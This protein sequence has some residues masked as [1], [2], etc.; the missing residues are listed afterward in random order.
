LNVVADYVSNLIDFGDYEIAPDAF[1]FVCVRAGQ[2]PEVDL[3][4]TA[5]NRKCGIFFSNTFEPGSAGIDAFN[6]D[7]SVF[8]LC[9]IF[10]NPAMIC[11]AIL[12]AEAC[13]ANILVLVP[14]W[15]NSYFYPFV[16]NFKD[17]EACKKVLILSGKMMFRAGF[18]QTTIFSERYDGNVEIWHLDFRLCSSH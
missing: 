6:Y 10:V 7:W 16:Q 2:V 15:K 17:C 5:Y 11:R 1:E 3:F 14:Q 9:W 4:A 18:D 12:Y 13:H 8:H